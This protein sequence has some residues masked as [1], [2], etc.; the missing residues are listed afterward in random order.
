MSWFGSGEVSWDDYNAA[1]R[2][3]R[4]RTATNVLEKIER[5]AVAERN[6][7]SAARAVITRANVEKGIRDEAAK[8]WLPAFA[9][10]IDA[11]PAE[12]Q[13]VLQLHLAHVY[14][15][16][17][18]PWRWGGARPTKLSDAAATNQPP[19]APERLNETLEKQFAK[20]LAHADELK[21]YRVQDWDDLLSYGTLPDAY[22]P[23][24]FDMVVHD[25][26]DFYGETI[27]DKALEKGLALLDSL[28]A[29]H[30]NDATKDALADAELARLRYEHSFAK[31]PAKERDARYAAALDA[32]IARYLD[33]TD[34]S[35]LAVHARAELLRHSGDLVGAHA[36]AATGAARW[37][38]SVGGRLC[39][40]LVISLERPDFTVTTESTWNAPWPDLAVSSKNMTNLFFRIVPVTFEDICD[41]SV[42]DNGYYR[43]SDM[44]K[45]HAKDASART[46]QVS[47]ED[48]RDYKMHETKLP[49]PS[50]LAP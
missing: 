14:R 4:P 11:A 9:A 45:R 36:K 15:D 42:W 1:M 5:K 28:I 29:F 8:D 39:T 24:L 37:P 31:L 17:S 25:I 23:T 48:P 41:S 26:V 27:P 50:D 13:G 6:W 32:F 7:P 22:R 21:T 10:R 46:W 30:R 49:V 40:S 19:W 47:L 20:V 34:V 18:R 2:K 44:L 43:A 35:A 12:L 38:E 3:G 16:E 33:V